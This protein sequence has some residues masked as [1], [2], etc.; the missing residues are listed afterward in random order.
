MHEGDL[1]SRRLA[2]R[3]RHHLTRITPHRLYPSK[4]DYLRQRWVYRQQGVSYLKRPLGY[5][6][7]LV[8][9]GWK[10]TLFEN[11]RHA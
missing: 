10:K 4:R 5:S 3:P 2:H 1:M 7:S 11:R 9:W 6:L 8:P